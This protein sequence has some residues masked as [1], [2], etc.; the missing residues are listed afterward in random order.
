M[1]SS[2]LE[3]FNE[4]MEKS[5]EHSSDNMATEPVEEGEV[6]ETLKIKLD[7]FVI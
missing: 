1:E 3:Q 2:V 6:C 4:K 7:P 5:E